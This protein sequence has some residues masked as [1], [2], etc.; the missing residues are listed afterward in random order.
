MTAPPP[1]WEGILDPGEAILWQGAPDRRWRREDIIMPYTVIGAL[2]ILFYLVWVLLGLGLLDGRAPMDQMHI[3]ALLPM[4]LVGAGLIWP[5]LARSIGRRAQFYTLTDRRAFI[6]EAAYLT[7]NRA[8]YPIHPDIPLMF[9]PGPP[10]TVWFALRVRAGH[11]ERIGFQRLDDGRAVYD[12]IRSL[13]DCQTEP[14][15]GLPAG[16]R[17]AEDGPSR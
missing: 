3:M 17:L 12:L 4:P 11:L 16:P 13:M 1:G 2:L 8:S 9:V 6:G 7:R 15:T 14:Q 10:D 5:H